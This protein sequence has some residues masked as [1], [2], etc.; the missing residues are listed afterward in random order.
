MA[1]N[2]VNLRINGTG[3]GITPAS[4]ATG[5]TTRPKACSR[6]GSKQCG[7]NRTTHD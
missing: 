6:V 7:K 5:R 2:A 1:R 4:L 3:V